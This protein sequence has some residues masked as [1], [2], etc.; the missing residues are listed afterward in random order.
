MSDAQKL[1]ADVHY[2]HEWRGDFLG[3]RCGWNWPEERT[4]FCGEEE[5]ISKA[6]SAHV[7]AEIDKA[8]GG[9]RVESAL[10]VTVNQT[11]RRI[12]L[13]DPTDISAARRFATEENNTLAD[14]SRWVSG[15]S[16]VQS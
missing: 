11:D 4:H 13:T 9:L 2:V 15:W 10:R 16:E 1:I 3:C 12:V 7:A 14:V 6:H 5:R 8:L